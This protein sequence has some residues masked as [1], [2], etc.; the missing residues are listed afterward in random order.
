MRATSLGSLVHL[1]LCTRPSAI[2]LET[3]ACCAAP[4]PQIRRDKCVVEA[5]RERQV[6]NLL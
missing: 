3:L 5:A 1:H 4:A 6:F 2:F